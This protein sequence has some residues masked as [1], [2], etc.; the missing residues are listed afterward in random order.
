MVVVDCGGCVSVGSISG[1]VHV[2]DQQNP[3]LK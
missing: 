2:S 3:L 1:G